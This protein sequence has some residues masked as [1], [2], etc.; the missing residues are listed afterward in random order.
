MHLRGDAFTVEQKTAN[1]RYYE[2]LTVRDSSLSA[3]TQAVIASEVGHLGLAYAYLA[4]A[5]LMDLDDLENN[6]RDGLHIVSLAGSWIC[7]GCG[8]RWP[9]ERTDSLGFAPRLP[10]DWIG[11]PS[12]WSSR[13]GICTSR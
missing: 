11:S 1:F 4:E 8:L 5:A 13:A 9:R 6:T 10:Q 3:C 7:T 2:S 12:T